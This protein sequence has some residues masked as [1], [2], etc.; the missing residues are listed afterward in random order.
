MAMS[1][2]FLKLFFC[3]IFFILGDGMLKHIQGWDIAKAVNK[4]YKAFIRSFA[5]AKATCQTRFP[6]K[7]HWICHFSRREKLLHSEKLAESITTF[8]L[9][10]TQSTILDKRSISVSHII[11]RNEK[12]NNKV[13]LRK[14]CPYSYF[15]AFGLNTETYGVSKCGK[16][17]TRETPNTSTFLTICLRGILVWKRFVVKQT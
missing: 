14:N 17:R 8:I 9:L 13:S 11:Q 4:D 6:C 3:I 2:N 7:Q 12:C 15:P 1:R 10:L 16:K 5:G